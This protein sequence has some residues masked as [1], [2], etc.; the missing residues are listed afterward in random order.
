MPLYEY[1]CKACAHQFEVLVRN[2]DRPGCPAC[3]RKELGRRF[4][5]LKLW[6]V[7]RSFGATSCGC[8]DWKTSCTTN[9]SSCQA[10]NSNVSLWREQW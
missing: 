2:G 6:M 9:R 10:A 5:A 8:W 3:H 4:R 7:I 1:S